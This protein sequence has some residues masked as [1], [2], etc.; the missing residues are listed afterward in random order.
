MTLR[1]ALRLSRQRPHRQQHTGRNHPSTAARPA[2]GTRNTGSRG[3]HHF[4]AAAPGILRTAPSHR[5]NLLARFILRSKSIRRVLRLSKEREKPGFHH[6]SIPIGCSVR[7][8]A[9]GARSPTARSRFGWTYRPRRGSFRP[10]LTAGFVCPRNHVNV[11][12][13]DASINT[14]APTASA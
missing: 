7:D 1:F 9:R 5:L 11:M 13:G 4:S 12:T 10:V 6:H 3:R 8:P 2:D 14:S